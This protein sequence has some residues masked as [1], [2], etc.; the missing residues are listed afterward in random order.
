[1][2]GPSL[3]WQQKHITGPRCCPGFSLSAWRDLVFLM[4]ARG[5]AVM[6]PENAKSASLALTK[7]RKLRHTGRKRR[8]TLHPPAADRTLSTVNGSVSASRALCKINCRHP[9]CSLPL[10]TILQM[11]TNR[12]A[13]YLSSQDYSLPCGT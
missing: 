10:Q 7:E 4:L 3:L 8:D 9:F 13:D 12:S 6:S 1:M 2:L 11:L 5:A